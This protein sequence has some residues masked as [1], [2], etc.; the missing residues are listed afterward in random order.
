MPNSIFQLIKSS[1]AN[2][3]NTNFETLERKSET[4]GE[5]FYV[6]IPKPK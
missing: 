6:V 4:T 3:N 5:V 2:F 1:F